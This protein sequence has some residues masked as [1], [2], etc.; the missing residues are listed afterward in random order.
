M[1]KQIYSRGT[2]GVR[3]QTQSMKAK[4]ESVPYNYLYPGSVQPVEKMDKTL[5]WASL[6]GTHPRVLSQYGTDIFSH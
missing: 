3:S 2:D 6:L 1:R 5:S 4:F